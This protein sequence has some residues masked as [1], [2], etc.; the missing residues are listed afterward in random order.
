M[1][2]T[3]SINAAIYFYQKQIAFYNLCIAC[4]LNAFFY[5][6]YGIY[7]IHAIMM[8]NKLPHTTQTQVSNAPLSSKAIFPVLYL[9]P[10][11]P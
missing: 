1:H 11:S 7:Y 4:V 8:N 9:H 3:L 10:P 6:L 2:V 5:T